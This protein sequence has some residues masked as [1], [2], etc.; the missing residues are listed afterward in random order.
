MSCIQSMLQSLSDRSLAQNQVAMRENIC[1]GE[2]VS[3]SAI[4]TYLRCPRSYRY[5][6]VQQETPE[7][8]ADDLL[9]GIAFHRAVAGFYVHFK[10]E[11]LA[12]PVTKLIE[13]WEIAL[14]REFAEAK[15]HIKSKSTKEELLERGKGMLTAFAESIKPRRIVTM[16][17]PFS[18]PVHDPRTG[19]LL[20]PT[21]V[22]SIDLIE[23]DDDGNLIVSDLKTASKKW[24]ESDV[25]LSLQAS[26]YSF[27]V[28][29]MGW[30]AN[31]EVLV[32]FDIVTKSTKPAL[33]QLYT[34][35]GAKDHDRILGVIRDV[36]Q[37]VEAK[38]FHVNPSWACINCPY[39]KV[40]ESEK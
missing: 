21:L 14:E 10:A 17:V 19:E 38:C 1:H 16:E 39:R 32:R 40:C 28:A 2:H 20:P 37:A 23:A 33:Q 7:F 3:F 9:F 8:V 11:G 31:D 36:Y 18:L 13:D 30:T 25:E 29:E 15:Y 5:K 27:V 6:Y 24:S 12:L 4:S 26:L 35:R 34:T 22:G